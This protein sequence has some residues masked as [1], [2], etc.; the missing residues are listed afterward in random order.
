ML[1]L[2]LRFAVAASLTLALGAGQT[3]LRAETAT[4][5]FDPVA[6]FTGATVGTGSLKKALTSSQATHVTG[7]GALRRDGVLVLDQ[8]VTIEREA[9]KTR[10]WQLRQ[11]G[12][13][14][15]TGTLSDAE[16]PVTARASV[17]QLT[18][19]YKMKDGMNVEQ[20]LTIAPDGQ[21]ARNAMK[22]RKLGFVA[23]TLNETIRR[24]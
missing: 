4:A 5:N 22:F 6:F 9:V 12:P 20:V 8:T 11:I 13:G 19:R 14:R 24:K 2:S 18:I 21:S 16:G 15:F 3:P 17:N 1:A 7:F 10:Q 23:A